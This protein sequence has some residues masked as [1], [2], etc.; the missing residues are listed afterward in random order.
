MTDLNESGVEAAAECVRAGLRTVMPGYVGDL[1]PREWASAAIT[2]YLRAATVAGSV[3]PFLAR[4]STERDILWN[5][6]DAAV[7]GMHGAIEISDEH[8]PSPDAPRPGTESLM[9]MQLASTI[10]LVETAMDSLEAAGNL[11]VLADPVAESVTPGGDDERWGTCENPRHDAKPQEWHPRN[12]T[13]I[14]WH[15]GPD[16]ATSELCPGSNVEGGQ[17]THESMVGITCQ[18]CARD[19]NR[20]QGDTTPPRPSGGRERHAARSEP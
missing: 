1:L 19:F 10:R 17:F 4:V 8:K 9:G 3:G 5:A 15:P 13:C 12:G 16:R 14:D 2:A 6:C 20:T 7:Q 11:S 18:V